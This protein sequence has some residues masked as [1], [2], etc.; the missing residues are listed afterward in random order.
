[1]A[2]YFN[3]FSQYADAEVPAD[4]TNRWDAANTTF[5]VVADAGASGGKFLRLNRA[6]TGRGLVSWDALDADINTDDI[7]IL[8]KYRAGLIT[9]TGGGISFRASGALNSENGYQMFFRA[10]SM[11]VTKYVN[12]VYGPIGATAGT[13]TANTWYFMRGRVEGGVL[14]LKHWT[15]LVTDEPTNWITNYVDTSIPGAGWAGL[16]A[17]RDTNHDFDFIGVGTNGEAAPAGDPASIPALTDI[18]GNN[19][20]VPGTTATVTGTNLSTTTGITVNG[21]A[22]TDVVVVN[23]TTVTFTVVRGTNPYNTSFQAV[24]TAG[25]G[26]DSVIVQQVPDVDEFVVT[27]SQP[28]TSDDASFWS[29]LIDTASGDPVTIV[30]GDQALVKNPNSLPNLSISPTGVIYADQTGDFVTQIWLLSE[31]VWGVDQTVTF[32][33][34]APAG[35]ISVGSISVTTTT[36]SI[37]FTYS[38][39]D[40][41]SFEY[42]LNDGVWGSWITVTSPIQLTGLTADSPYTVEIRPFT[43]GGPG[44]VA[45]TGFTTEAVP[46]DPPAGTITFSTVSVTDD[47]ATVPFSY[48]DVDQDGFEYRLLGEVNW[49][50]KAASPISLLVLQPDQNYTLF[51]RA[52]NSAGVSEESSIAFRTLEQAVGPPQGKLTLAVPTVGS[53]LI[54]QQFF[55]ETGDAAYY[56]YKVDA[57]PWVAV[58]HGPI[59]LQNLTPSTAYT[60]QVRPVNAEGTGDTASTTITTKAEA[61]IVQRK[62]IKR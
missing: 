33:E 11:D 34:A 22:Q 44:T 46:V 30:D 24:L 25:G 47:T 54:V 27:A 16:Y 5:S 18:N 49:V 31:Q 61:D 28:N 58:T 40:T 62:G 51:V 32:A 20:V 4:F 43:T 50:R 57:E 41:P 52:Y 60:I 7:E 1:M 56:E 8:V 35:S 29:G 45:S 9:E 26:S 13:F 23:A 59:G 42:R 21:I 12:N 39:T 17:F 15:G 48:S 3:N 55:Y 19:E 10:A 38:G 6:V 2:Q 37:P 14:Y 53:D 36:A